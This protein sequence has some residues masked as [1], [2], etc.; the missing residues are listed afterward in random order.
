MPIIPSYSLSQ[1][2]EFVR[3][4]LVVPYVRVTSA[5]VICDGHDFSFYCHPYLLKLTFPCL[6]DGDDEERCK[7]VYN[8]DED[9]GTIVA[10]L[11]KRTR[12][13][14]FPDLDLTTLLMQRRKEKDF[15][16][17]SV[18]GSASIEVLCSTLQTN[19]A[20]EDEEEEEE[21]GG[22]FAEREFIGAP[23]LLTSIPHYGF[24]LKY[25][26]MFRSFREELVEMTELE[27]PDQVGESSRRVLRLEAEDR[28]FD[29]ERY[30]GDYF[31]AESDALFLDAMAY[32]PFWSLEWK[33]RRS[34]ASASATATSGP[35]A[36]ENDSGSASGSYFSE[37]EEATLKELPNRE[38]IFIP[39]S[40]EEKGEL[41]GLAD[42]LYSFCFEFRCTGGELSVE[43]P[44]N[45][46]RLSALL[47]WLD[48]YNQP[49]D[50][51]M[52]VI[53]S[54]ARRSLIYPYVRHWKL[55][56]KVLADVA[57]VLYL[58]KRCI[59]RCLLQCHSLMAHTDSHYMLNKIFLDDYCVWIQRLRPESIKQLAD[60]INAA[61]G[62]IEAMEQAGRGIVELRLPELEAWALEQLGADE[63]AVP[64]VLPDVPAELYPKPRPR[65]RPRALEQSSPPPLPPA[66]LEIVPP[67]RTLLDKEPTITITPQ[68]QPRTLIQVISSK[69]EEE[70]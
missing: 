42:V 34:T 54:A 14:L 30:L 31:G 48:A 16:G 10:S 33:A 32:E 24:G 13:E 29:P 62:R 68:D 2:D 28:L 70:N 46:T 44:H 8:P 40:P 7:A 35:S 36:S 18:S 39:G 38:Y 43:S 69:D 49:D 55:V 66:I 19:P 41:L 11:P 5:E 51:A 61:K 17:A 1:D 27:E 45:I 3:V 63:D 59:L 58:G 6:L 26:N 67:Q 47:S 50:D 56:R 25:S 4:R 12:G 9:H 22:G 53:V 15:G 37:S 64:E 65:P 57:K 23:P 52:K 20:G 60:E 21:R